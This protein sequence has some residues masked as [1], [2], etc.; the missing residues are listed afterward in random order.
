[1]KKNLY[2]SFFV[3]ILF[4][5]TAQVKAGIIHDTGNG[6]WDNGYGL[7]ATQWVA[8]QFSITENYT[9]TSITGAIGT[10]VGSAGDSYSLTLVLYSNDTSVLSGGLPGVELYSSGFSTPYGG[11]IDLGGGSYTVPWRGLSGLNWDVAPGT[12]WAAFEIRP[13]DTFNG[14]ISTAVADPLGNYAVAATHS[15]LNYYEYDSGI[16][17]D[18]LDAA[19]KIEGDPVPIPSTISLLGLGILG[20]AGIVRRKK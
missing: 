1:M 6:N 13:G 10:G 9:I 4:F 5:S 3:L 19:F 18:D 2:F 11:W 20:F 7:S 8:G 17:P 14:G 15:S 16:Y 12:Y